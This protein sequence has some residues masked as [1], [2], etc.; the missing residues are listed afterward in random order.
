MKE[1]H[2]AST[3]IDSSHVFEPL[4]REGQALLHIPGAKPLFMWLSATFLY[5]YQFFL[6]SSPNVMVDDLMHDFQ[7]DAEALGIL[8][9][10]YY[11]AYSFLQ[12]P[13]GIMIDKF[14]LRRILTFSAL[15]C[16]LGATIFGISENLLTAKVGR[17]FIGIGSA[18]VF[19]SCLKLITL[20]FPKRHFGI[21]VGFTMM[22]GT[23]GAINA[24]APLAFLVQ[25]V[26]WRSA[27]L[28]VAVVGAVWSLVLWMFVRDRK[29]PVGRKEE[30][31]IPVFEGLRLILTNRQICCEKLPPYRF[32]LLTRT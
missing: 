7:V 1:R 10:F 3:A 12:I 4:S 26:G 8:A 25:S 21:F 2:T 11:I 28:S 14:G 23:F 6:R 22:M 32:C 16:S 17:L 30:A 19:L 31:P 9:S 20:W 15:T 27:I 5:C 29:A 24:G 13:M 18:G